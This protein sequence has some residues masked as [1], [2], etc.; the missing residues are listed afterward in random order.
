GNTADLIP[1]PIK[2]NVDVIPIKNWLSTNFI[3][4]DRSAIFNDPVIPYKIPIPVKKNVEANIL[5]AMYFTAPSSCVLRPPKVIK[6]KEDM[7]MTSNQTY[8]LN[9]SPV[10]NA[11]FKPITKKWKIGK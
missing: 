3:F 6:T 10:K 8:K 1:K 7:I 4:C 11:P 2:K 9:I 5:R